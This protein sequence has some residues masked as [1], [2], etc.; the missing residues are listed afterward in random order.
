[1]T[2]ITISRHYGTGGRKIAAR[3][4]ELLDYRFFDRVFMEQVATEVGLSRGE[5]ADFS[6]EDFKARSFLERITSSIPA[7][8]VINPTAL[9]NPVVSTFDDA[10]SI[11]MIT[12]TVKRAYQLDNVVIVGRG[13]QV[14]LRDQPQVLHVLIVA[15]VETRLK[16]LQEVE[17]LSLQEAGR[18]IEARDKAVRQYLEHFFGVQWD[19][20][21]LY[22]LVIN[23]GLCELEQA[24]QLIVEASRLLV[25]TTPN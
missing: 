13:S 3:V 15:P 18:Q 14:I 8:M 21:L 12:Q 4:R 24:A 16:R 2:T 5:I 1:M 19:D 11:N 23:T 7:D 20:P 9:I 17:G 22:H 10:A 25:K 6:E